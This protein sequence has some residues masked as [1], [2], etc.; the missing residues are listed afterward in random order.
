[1]VYTSY[2]LKSMQ[3][4]THHIT[5]LAMVSVLPSSV[6]VIKAFLQRLNR[7]YDWCLKVQTKLSIL[8][9]QIIKQRTIHL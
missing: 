6:L 9:T 2:S 4:I 1:M 7:W 5:T 3:G 8:Y